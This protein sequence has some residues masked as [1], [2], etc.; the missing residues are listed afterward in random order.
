MGKKMLRSVLVAAFSAVLAFGALSGLSG[1]KGDIRADST[2]PA[3][4]K[5]V[6]IVQDSTWPVA[7]AGPGLPVDDGSGS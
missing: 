7:P 3:S 4:A 2:W 6:A 5:A 1:T